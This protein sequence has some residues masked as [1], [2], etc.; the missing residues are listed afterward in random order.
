MSTNLYRNGVLQMERKKS[1]SFNYGLAFTLLLFFIISCV[2]IFNAQQ[3]G[4]YTTNFVVKQVEWYIVGGVIIFMMMRPD[5]DQ[6]NRITW[7]FYGFTIFIL[8]LLIISPTSIAPLKNNAKSWFV[9]PGIGSIQPSEFMKISLILAFSKVIQQHNEKFRVRDVS[10]DLLLIG[11]LGA[12]L[13]IPILLIMQ[14]PDLGTALVMI[15]LFFMMLFISGVTWKLI[16]PIFASMGVVASIILYMVLNHAAILEKYLHLHPY[17]FN[18]IYAWF[19]PESY[20]GSLSYNY[21]QVVKA[22]GSGS[23]SGRDTSHYAVYVPEKH[24]DFIFSAIG[25]NYG[26]VG[27]SLVLLLFMVLIYQIITV[28]FHTKDKYSTY[29]CTGIISVIFF[30]VL[31]NVGM[32]IGLLPIT[33]IPLPFISYGGSSLMS[34]MCLMGLVLNIS[35]RSNVYIFDQNER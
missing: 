30:H 20:A 12:T 2:A 28:A 17:Q 22:I 16:L 3:T 32:C 31:E 21:L 29:I 35:F 10:S 26:F 6:L 1:E 4:Q 19:D 33:G 25:E 27:T 18:R 13:S 11:K 24:S 23:I 14:Q 8:I 5:E 15:F 9:L 7:F 34:S